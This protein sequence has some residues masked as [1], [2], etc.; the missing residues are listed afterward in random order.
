PPLP[1]APAIEPGAQPPAP[2]TS[3]GGG[4]AHAA[5]SQAKQGVLL[6][7]DSLTVG[8]KPFMPKDID[9]A[10]VTVDATGGIPLKE[11]MRR[12]DAVKDKPRVVEMA[13]FTNNSPGQIDE[14]RSAIE[15]TVKDARER[16]G[17][18]VWATIVR[19]GDYG[20][21]NSM[22]RDMA[23]KNSDVMGLVDWARM[24][25]DKP[26]LVGGDGVHSGP[27]GYKLRAQA[28]VD[29]AKA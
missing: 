5:T 25:K 23:A 19:P 3:G 7:G 12:Y 27:D 18:V 4:A 21:V 2:G 20:A 28:F 13:L 26:S 22:I 6:I 10:P 17:R 9:G 14:L 15:K 1:Q 16:G 24:V 8:V 29:A 11:G